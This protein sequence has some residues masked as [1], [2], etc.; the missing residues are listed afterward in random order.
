MS[1]KLSDY[2]W[3]L[4][5]QRWEAGDTLRAIADDMG[6]SSQTIG[7][8]KKA[9]AWT[10]PDP[11]VVTVSAYAGAVEVTDN[12]DAYPNPSQE[13]SLAE[14]QM[15]ARALQP[16]EDEARETI[17]EA[18]ERADLDLAASGPGT[19]PVTDESMASIHSATSSVATGNVSGF[20]SGTPP[21]KAS[22][23]GLEVRIAELEAANKALEAK[24]VDL[25]DSADVELYDT[26]EQVLEVVGVHNIREM[27]LGRFGM[28]N[29]KRAKAGKPPLNLATDAPDYLEDQIQRIAAELVRERTSHIN[30]LHRLR[31][32]K[33]V[34]SDGTLYQLPMEE[35][36]N[37]MAGEELAP[38][39]KARAKG[40][41]IANPYM[42]Q[43]WNC[44]LRSPRNEDQ[45]FVY[46]GYCSEAHQAW[47]PYLNQKPTPGVS[48]SRREALVG[49][50]V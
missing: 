46:E 3:G 47:D 19:D 4:A 13:P 23:A 33:M 32:V 9:E 31:C 36:I 24:V 39:A 5:R 26:E 45:S 18:N 14:V 22:T 40:H 7:V 42:C 10:R 8:R 28:E 37:N 43:V 48:T 50:S 29:L 6:V 27:A 11:D 44:W 16:T 30:S 15:E 2:L 41:K 25:R 34:H 17:D 35:Q 1:T 38:M 49:G 21:T 12:V 20:V